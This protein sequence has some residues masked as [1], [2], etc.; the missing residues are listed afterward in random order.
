MGYAHANKWSY[1]PSPHHIQKVIQNGSYAYMPVLKYKT[2]RRKI[3]NKTSWHSPGNGILDD[4][5]KAKTRGKKVKLN[6]I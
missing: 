3:R 4:T 1:I 6:L 5:P 2:L